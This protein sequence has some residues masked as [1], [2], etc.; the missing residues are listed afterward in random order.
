MVS[1]AYIIINDPVFHQVAYAT[2]VLAVVGRAILLLHKV[3]AQES[4]YERAQMKKLLILAA[5]GFIVG[6]T[7]WNIDNIFCST[8]RDWRKTVPTFT[9]SVS[10]VNE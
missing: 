1:Y 9:G 6:F 10:E 3:S 4:M 5:A 8:L 2:L 7:L